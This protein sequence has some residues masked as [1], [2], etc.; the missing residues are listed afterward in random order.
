MVQI[1]W[2]FTNA[3]GAESQEGAGKIINVFLE[4]RGDEQSITWRRSPGAKAFVS[5]PVDGALA[6]SSMLLAVSSVVNTVGT[7]AGRAAVAGVVSQ[8]VVRQT[9]GDLRGTS[10]LTGVSA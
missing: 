6:G 10:A 1:P 3:P 8:V 9:E 7:L 4:R 5:D 2:P